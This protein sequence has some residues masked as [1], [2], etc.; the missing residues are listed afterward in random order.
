[1]IA[2]F[3]D[4]GP[5]GPYVGQLH[6]GL[7]QQA[8]GTAVIQLHIGATDLACTRIYSEVRTGQGVWYENANGPV[9]IAANLAWAS[10]QPGIAVG[11]SVGV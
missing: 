8:P 9:E 6:A 1:M 5:S 10:D 2:L 11:D 7:A 3:T 4:F